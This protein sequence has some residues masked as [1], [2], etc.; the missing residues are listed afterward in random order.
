MGTKQNSVFMWIRSTW[1]F[2]LLEGG[3]NNIKNNNIETVH[4]YRKE[5][6]SRSNPNFCNAGERE[7]GLLR[8]H[9]RTR[10]LSNHL[11]V[12]HVCFE[13]TRVDFSCHQIR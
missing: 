6:F 10:L 2:P 12:V 11:T 5:L 4:G 13:L 8:D 7:R 3:T 1:N 9:L